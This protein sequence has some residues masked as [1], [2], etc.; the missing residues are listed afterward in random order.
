MLY[1]PLCGT[2]NSLALWPLR[3]LLLFFLVSLSNAGN[4]CCLLWLGLP[5][6]IL[7]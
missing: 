6:I 1:M 3:L 2:K 5:Q 4:L 7:R